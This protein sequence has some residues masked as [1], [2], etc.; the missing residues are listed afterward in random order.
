MNKNTQRHNGHG[1]SQADSAALAEAH[2]EKLIAHLPRWLAR[3]VHWIRRPAAR[4]V[5]I[6]A[7]LLLF[8]GSM[9]FF[10]PVL[11]LWMLPLSLVLLAEDIPPLR[12]AMER[13]INWL[14]ERRPQWFR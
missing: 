5:R 11:G 13:F 2:L 6:P 4:W 12:H 10:L 14:A 3:G 7:A 8:V 1:A 9:L